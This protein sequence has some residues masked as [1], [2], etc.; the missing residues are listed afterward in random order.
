MAPNRGS[1]DAERARDLRDRLTAVKRRAR[2]ADGLGR[3]DARRPPPLVGS[4][5][6]VRRAFADEVD[7]H[8]PEGGEHMDQEASPARRDDDHD[9]VAPIPARQLRCRR[10]GDHR[11]RGVHTALQAVD[12]ETVERSVGSWCPA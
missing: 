10:T 5:E 8:L 12:V 1:R 3:H 7:L 9:D 2:R 11:N 4:H 6:A